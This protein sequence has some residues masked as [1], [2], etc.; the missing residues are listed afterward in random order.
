MR[1]IL[2]AAFFFFASLRAA[3]APLSAAQALAHEGKSATVE[4]AVSGASQTAAGGV[5][6]YSEKA[7]DS[8]NCFYVRVSADAVRALHKQGVADACSHFLG[9]IVRVT[10]AVKSITYEGVS[11]KIGLIEVGDLSAIQLVRARPDAVAGEVSAHSG[12]LVSSVP[13]DAAKPLAPFVPTANYHQREMMG[14]T[15]LISPEL[16]VRVRDRDAM[17]KSLEKQMN[18]IKRVLT[19]EQFETLRQT[20]IW[21]EWENPALDSPSAYMG[22]A[23]W[24][25]LRGLNPEKYGCIEINNTTKFLQS[26]ARAQPW[27]L[28]HE[29]A[30]AWH[31]KVLGETHPGILKAYADA[32]DQ[33]LY[34]SVD[35]YDGLKKRRAYAAKNRYEYFAELSEAWFG[36]NDYFP[37]TREQLQQY[38]PQGFKLMQ[39]VWGPTPRK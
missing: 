34:D 19:A 38:D 20:K 9:A 13:V 26:A 27:I 23:E 39:D 36:K 21:I 30:H 14:F 4:F 6:L 16:N 10:G 22:S 15:L 3:D 7:W 12:S 31:F 18:N 35:Y 25:K 32:M 8:P 29:L 33:H 24:I 11:G 5:E 1:G 28:M 2:F 17:L 37:F